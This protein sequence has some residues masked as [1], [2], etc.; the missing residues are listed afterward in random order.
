[1]TAKSRVCN[2]A[3]WWT[4]LYERHDANAAICM[5]CTFPRNITR[6]DVGQGTVSGQPHSL[7][8]SI[9]CSLSLFWN[10]LIYIPIF[11]TTSS[12][13]IVSRQEMF[14]HILS[15]T[16]KF[17]SLSFLTHD[18]PVPYSNLLL[19]N[20]SYKYYIFFRGIRS[21]FLLKT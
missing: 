1:M 2:V 15:T 17:S 16:S 3:A 21:V 20:A 9:N 6:F 10:K 11:L 8:V 5:K 4:L 13:E 7:D 18:D 12:F 19:T 14:R